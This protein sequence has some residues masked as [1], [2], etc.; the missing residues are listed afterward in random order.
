[1]ATGYRYDRLSLV[2]DEGSTVVRRADNTN[3]WVARKRSDEAT[4]LIG[5]LSS[6]EHDI[7]SGGVAAIGDERFLVTANSANQTL[8]R[9]YIQG[10]NEGT[11]S[12]RRDIAPSERMT[13]IARPKRV[14]HRRVLIT[15]VTESDQ[16]EL[17]VSVASDS[18]EYDANKRVEHP[19][20]AAWL[21]VLETRE[22]GVFA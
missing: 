1:M 3:T 12:W 20:G 7:T 22:S 9:I 2:S 8:R 16:L 11:L 15:G 6:R 4:H 13:R 5:L 14:S 21:T 17:P 10:V 19:G 18:I